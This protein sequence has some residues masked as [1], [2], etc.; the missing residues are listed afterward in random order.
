MLTFLL[1]AAVQAVPLPAVDGNRLRAGTRCF[2]LSR[3]GQVLGAVRQTVAAATVNGTPVW[4]IVIHQR[5]N[6]GKFDMRDH[7]VLRRADLSPVSM[8][9]QRFGEEH[10]RV[11]YAPGKITTIRKGAAPVETAVSG[12]IWDGNLWGLTFAALPLAGGGH[13]ELPFYQYDKGLGRFVADVVGNETVQTP[14]GPVEAWVVE[15]DLGRRGKV[16][17]QIGKADHAELGNVA[18]PFAQTLGGD[19]SAIGGSG[20]H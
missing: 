3:E 14:E 8:E 2:A 15:L 17:Y 20:E 12:P 11:S 13:Y 7:F 16:R 19:C 18:G 1:L 9:N 4:D 6:D 5:L 10:V